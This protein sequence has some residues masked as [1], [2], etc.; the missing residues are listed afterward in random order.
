ML[1]KDLFIISFSKFLLIIINVV[2]IKIMTSLLSPEEMG[3]IYIFITILSFFSLFFINP[4]TQYFFRFMNDWKEKFILMDAIYLVTLY[5]FLIS[6]VLLLTSPLITFFEIANGFS[7]KVLILLLFFTLVFQTQNQFIISI[8]NMLHFRLNFTILNILTSLFLLIFGYIFIK[9]FGE[10]AENWLLGILLTNL[11]FMIIGFFILKTKVNQ[12]FSGIIWN[13]KRIT[14]DKIKSILIFA[15]PLSIAT[16]FMWLQNSGYRILIE[17]NLGLEFLGFLGVGL[18]ISAQISST[19]E[20]I[21]MQYFHPIYYQQITN[22]TLVNRKEAIEIFINKALP[23]YFMLAIFLTFLSKYIVEILVSEK[24]FGVYIFT[25]FG[26]WIEFFRMTSNLFGNISQSEINTKKF[27]LPYI[28]GSS[29]TISLVYLSI[30]TNEYETYLPCALLIGGFFTMIVMYISMQK[31]IDFRINFKLI[32][33]AF[34][35]SIPYISA[36]FFNFE[37]NLLL[38]MIII[39]GFGLYFLGTVL[40]IYKKGLNDNC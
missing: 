19:V 34:I 6:L 20:S 35:I 22:A 11:I 33:L 4:I 29:L 36:Y 39:I 40:Y 3:N 21:V 18:A 14:K 30:L 10:N 5:F 12:F 26:I 16:L 13:L 2:S 15:F 1:N 31:L 28:I 37:S 38:N 23:I 24:Y 25:T 8:L 27:M 9:I 32:F 17:Q 7:F